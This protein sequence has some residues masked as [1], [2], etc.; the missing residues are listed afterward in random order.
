MVCWNPRTDF[1]DEANHAAGLKRLLGTKRQQEEKDESSL[2]FS[3]HHHLWCWS[4]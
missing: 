3:N 2:F 1:V 4:S